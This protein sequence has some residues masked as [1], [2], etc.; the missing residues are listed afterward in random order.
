MRN[1]APVAVMIN[2]EVNYRLDGAGA[3]TSLQPPPGQ[4][5][6]LRFPDVD[7]AK[8]PLVVHILTSAPVPEGKHY[9]IVASAA[10]GDSTG[11]QTL[12]L[13]CSNRDKHCSFVSLGNYPAR[14]LSGNHQLEILGKRFV[15]KSWEEAEFAVK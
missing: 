11:T 4:N 2:V 12:S 8:Y 14:W 3:D 5:A 13:A 1:G 10:L 15:G 7:L 6:A 9:G